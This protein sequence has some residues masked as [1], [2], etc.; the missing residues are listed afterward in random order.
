MNAR[1]AWTANLKRGQL[2][3]AANALPKPVV[4]PGGHSM[5]SAAIKP[6]PSLPK[7]LSPFHALPHS[8]GISPEVLSG[9]GAS[10]LG[11]A[12]LSCLQAGLPM[13]LIAAMLF[14]QSRHV[15]AMQQYGVDP[16]MLQQ[17]S[18]LASIPSIAPHETFEAA[19]LLHDMA[20]GVSQSRSDE[21]EPI[22]TSASELK[23]ETDTHDT[24][25]A[26]RKPRKSKQKLITAKSGDNAKQGAAGVL[27][28]PLLKVPADAKSVCIT[29]TSPSR[30][31]N[32][33]SA[34]VVSDAGQENQVPRDEPSRTH[35]STPDS[36]HG[37]KRKAHSEDAS[38]PPETKKVKHRVVDEPKKPE[39]DDAKLT[40]LL[41][42][43]FDRERCVWALKKRGGRVDR[44][45]E[46]L[47][48]SS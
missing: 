4:K 35:L 25:A 22:V 16:T 46:L 42:L 39:E 44:A 14:Q 32:A 43:G 15:Q 2:P 38:P 18:M 48:L 10:A 8:V 23:G 9:P 33:Q 20:G 37:S 41:S 1:A 19:G 31:E 27:A 3:N 30:H 45:A 13:E 24:Q 34:A 11:P 5:K 21:A 28:S 40:G 36:S 29:G 26:V 12:I 47:L 17:A 7:G 6:P